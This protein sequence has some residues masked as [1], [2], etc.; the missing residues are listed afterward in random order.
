M[1]SDACLSPVIGALTSDARRRVLTG[2]V[3][4]RLEAGELLLLS[5]SDGR[6]AYVM[7]HGVVKLAMRDAEGRETI[8]GL[9]VPGDV[10]GDV[11]A[12]DRLCQPLDA[13]AATRVHALGLDADVLV[14]VAA[15]NARA[16]L[17]LARSMATKA[18]WTYETARERTSGDVSA[19]L[20]GRLL[21]L[22]EVLGRTHPP[23]LEFELPLGQED[24]ARFAGMC[25][26]SACRTLKHFKARGLIDYERRTLRILRPDALER[27]RCAG[28]DG[29]PFR[30]ASA[31]GNRRPRSNPDT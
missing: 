14:E 2:A 31:T 7:V 16:S 9:A 29:E 12:L 19:R 26:E 21:H 10:V 5:G 15:R 30:L 3:W 8:L 6:R 17:E 24:L 23:S 13:I 11:A 18:R 20:A 27:I 25:R 28:R 1:E 4:R 22:A